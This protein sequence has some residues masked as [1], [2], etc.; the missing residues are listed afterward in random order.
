MMPEI[1]SLYFA[2]FPPEERR[3]WDDLTNK[4]KQGQIKL[5]SFPGGF[6]TLWNFGDFRYIEHF[7]VKPELRGN[8]IGGEIL[9]SLTTPLVLEIEPKHA[10]PEAQRRAQFYVRHSF[11][12]H[13]DFPYLQP[14]Y[15]PELPSV[16]MV[17]CTRGEVP[18]LKQIVSLLQQKVYSK[19]INSIS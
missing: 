5:K 8:G 4:I 17:L 15:A 3:D 6:M 2:S 18:D 16:P 14:P 13:E 11:T 10:N 1:R 12:V 19:C 7:A 9:D